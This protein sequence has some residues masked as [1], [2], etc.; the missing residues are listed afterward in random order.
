MKKFLSLFLVLCLC[1]SCCAAFAEEKSAANILTVGT[2]EMN[3]EFIDG[4]GSSSYDEWVKT[5]IHGFCAT[6]EVTSAGQYV[7]NEQVV[8]K[9]DITEDEAGNKTYT[10]KLCEDLKWSDG[11]SITA[12]DY[13]F[14]ILWRASDEWV[15]A[16]ASSSVGE[17]L[18]GYSEYLTGES[19]IF[20]GVK[21]IDDYTFSVT[22]AAENL[23][24]YFEFLYAAIDPMC[25]AVYGPELTIVSDD[26]GS[27]L[28]GDIAAAMAKVSAG[29]R[30]APT[31]AC[32]PYKFISFENQTA[33]L[34]INEY[35][36]GDLDGNKPT[37]EYVV[38]K[39]I[40]QDTDHDAVISGSV[41]LI[42]GVI[43]GNKIETCRS[44]ETVKMQSYLR[45]GYGMLTMHCDWGP[46]ADP[47]VRWALA[48]LVDRAAV[49]DYVLGG[50]GGTVD[51]AYGY[52][53]WMYEEAGDELEEGLTSF[54]LNIEK[55]NEYLDK[56]E[57]IYEADG[58]T[59][60][61]ASKANADGSYLRYNADGE[62]LAIHHMGTD[63]NDVTDIVEI[64]Y[65]ANAPLAGIAF[66][67]TRSDFN[68]LLDNFYY[69]FELGDDRYYSTFNMGTSFDAAYDPYYSWHSDWIGTWYN[70]CQLSDEELDGYIEA[71]R[72]AT[73][74]E[75]YLNAWLEFE[76]RWQELLPQIGLYSNEYFDIYSINVDGVNTTPFW[77]YA[78]SICTITKTEG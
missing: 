37:I 67:V 70:S 57:W 58:V 1:L 4:F 59:P 9:E 54:G 42:L 31:I 69:G 38:Q 33:T 50:Y 30:F 60:F 75:E 35:F 41:D 61:D 45:N 15:T 34:Q 63:E 55:A 51:A 23:P 64:Q 17:C 18:V 78:D 47:N 53:Q 8:E 7:L 66:D 36:K 22:I 2:P 73:T 16:G 19:D 62:V 56:T 25:A 44:A 76:W 46:T 11:S 71:M 10:F 27:Y 12:K 39:S 5:M 40:P 72:A 28:D 13:V 32:G 26:N 21:L 74:D 48:Y 14:A 29:E 65:T 20:P 52:A 68:A 24:Y 6:Y 49:C 43:E 3:G 77:S